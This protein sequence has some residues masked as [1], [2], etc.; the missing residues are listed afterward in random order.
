M[1]QAEMGDT[2]KV[3]YTGSLQDGTVFDSSRD[4]EPMEVT[5]GSGRLIGGFEDSLVGMSVGDTKSLKILSDDAYGPRREELVICVEKTDF[6]ANLEPREGLSLNLKGPE[7][8]VIQAI[9]TEVSGDSVTIDANHPLAGKDLN[10]D[11]ELILEFLGNTTSLIAAILALPVLWFAKRSLAD[12]NDRGGVLA[13]WFVMAVVV[14][15]L[16]WYG[17]MYVAGKFP[18]AGS[19]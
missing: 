17:G 14:F 19:R 3:H 7:E 8:Q 13:I 15:Y 10:F 12:E 4:R 1:R 9:I 5:L 2:V 11:I 16:F 18:V 6:H